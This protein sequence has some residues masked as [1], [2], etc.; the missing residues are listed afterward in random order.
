MVFLVGPVGL[1]KEFGRISDAVLQAFELTDLD[2][3]FK[4]SHRLGNVSDDNGW[5]AGEAGL[6]LGTLT[7]KAGGG[8]LSLIRK[9]PV[10]D[11]E[12]N[13]GEGLDVLELILLVGDLTACSL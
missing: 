2:C 5:S 13:V 6:G 10:G 9:M 1:F 11:V 12:L 7:T 4:F 3:Q 8:T